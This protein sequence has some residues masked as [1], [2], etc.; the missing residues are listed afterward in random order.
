MDA[1]SPAAGDGAAQAVLDGLLARSR[2]VA[3]PC[4]DGAMVWRLWGKAGRARPPVVLLHGGYGAWNH[5]VRTIPH[6]ESGYQVI[7]ADLPGCGDSAMPAEPYDMASLAALVAQ[8]L[9]AV[10]PGDAP[11]DLVSF[12]FGGLL[13]PHIARAQ[14]RRIRS[15]TIVG[16][17]VLGL[18]KTGR[19]N[20][21]VAVPRDLPAA[22]AAPLYRGNLEKLMVNDPAAVDELAMTLHMANMA[23]ARLPSRRLARATV[24][25]EALGDLPCRL[26]WVFGEGDVTLYPDLAG[27]RAWLAKHYPAAPCHVVAG[28]GHWVQYEAAERFNALLGELLGAAGQR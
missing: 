21:L 18:N 19:A 13:S 7:A 12:S 5:W 23:K 6:L 16:T 20:E 4:G 27:V 11:F 15:L 22:E 8:G 3:T 9:D 2:A 24:L 26:A 10:I 1:T 14:A 25:A 28:A 17:P